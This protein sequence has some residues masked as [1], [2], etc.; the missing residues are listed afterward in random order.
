MIRFRCYVCGLFVCCALLLLLLAC[1]SPNS[2]APSAGE[3]HPARYLLE[4]GEAA[5][6]DLADCQT[7]HQSDLAGGENVTSCFSCHEPDT[8]FALHPLPYADPDQ[9]GTAARNDQ[10]GCLACHGSAPNRFDGGIIADENLYASESATC[11]SAD[12]HPSAGAHPTNWQGSNDINGNGYSATH[13]VVTSTAIDTSC[14]LCHQISQGGATPLAEAPSC[15][16]A[17]FTNSDGSTTGC[18]AGGPGEGAHPIPYAAA[19]LHGGSA[20]ADL[21]ACQVCHGTAGTTDFDGGISDVS[22]AA[23]ECHPAAGAHP[24]RWLGDNDI[25]PAYTSTHRDAAN[26]ETGCALCH[27]VTQGRTPPNTA[28]PS[29]F[30]A[31]FTN[32]DGSTSGCHSSGPGTVPHAL[33]YTQPSEHG[34]A[35]KADLIAC[36][37]CHGTPGTTAFNGGVAATACA[38][39]DC[40]PVAGAHPTN[41][42]GENDPSPS[43]RSSHRNAGQQAT[44]CALCH[45]FTDGRTPPLAEAPSC[46]SASFTN[47]DGST[48]GCHSD[49]PGAAHALPFTDPVDHGPEAKADLTACVACHATPADAGPGDNP[50]FNLTVGDLPQGCETS[51]CHSPFT[52]HP[53]PLWAGAE[54]TSHV[55]AGNQAEACAMCHG[56]TLSGE[57]AAV[58]PACTACHELGSPLVRS[59]CTSCHATPPNNNSDASGNRPNRNGAHSAH[60]G[61]AG[62]T[63]NCSVCHNGAGANANNHFDESAP[64]TI[65]MLNTYNAKGSS[66]GFSAASHTCSNIRCHGGRTTPNWFSGSI[67]V[68]TDCESCHT[69]GTSEYNGYF[70]GEHGEHRGEGIA[71]IRCHD[72][73][74][75]ANPNGAHLSNLASTGFEQDPWDTILPLNQSC[76][77]SGCHGSGIDFGDWN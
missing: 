46:F 39:V 69:F 11:A 64:A 42:Q 48:S 50:R 15:Y 59:D 56:E 13:Q 45:D 68:A 66:A 26:A 32:S 2:L 58:G 1:S 5:R 57:G 34:G 40:H 9:H 53:V 52:A 44:N 23:A 4:H 17:T 14:A 10:A 62:V 33:P 37:A 63:D 51:G 61:Y 71:C 49:G 21:A 38:A 18:H 24:T 28:A 41:W 77:D 6:S 70:S 73:A 72:A 36:Q 25:T 76:R 75:L 22:C 20:K 19:N 43:Y 55:S 12:C 8:D 29:C 67:N 3:A 35:A 47:S 7:C 27:D 54:A 16:S 74:K 60:Q 30:S 31:S 65:R